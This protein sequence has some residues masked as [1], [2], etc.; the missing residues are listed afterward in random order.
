[1][2]GFIIGQKDGQTQ[3][4]DTEGNLIPVTRIVTSPCF[5]TNIKWTDAHAYASVQ[6]GLG[7]AK[8]IQKPVKGQLTK[9]GIETPLRFL[10]EIRIK[11]NISE[12]TLI[13]EEGKKGLQIG[14]VKLFVGQEVKP[15][16]FFKIGDVVDASGTSKGKGFQGVIRRYN[17]KGG[18]RTHGQSDRERARGSLGSG[19]TPG[20]VFRGLRMAGRKG[21]A[22]V[23]VQNLQVVAIE[24]QSLLIKGLVPGGKGGLIEVKTHGL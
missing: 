8:R 7:V 1:M 24:D 20:R 3:T 13:E 16:M 5:I 18:P 12:M 9:A 21:G 2:A 10:K 23:T 6:L 19:T 4:F 11:N 15:E 14:E 22:R 17:F